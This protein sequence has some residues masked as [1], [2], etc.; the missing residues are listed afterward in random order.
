M[1]CYS[2]AGVSDPEQFVPGSAVSPGEIPAGAVFVLGSFDGVHRGHRALFDAALS[3]ARESDPASPAD[4]A[5]VVVWSLSGLHRAC[6]TTEDEKRVLFRLCGES[7]CV[8]EDFAEIRALPGDTF[9]FDRL[10]AAFRPRAVVCGFNFTFGAGASCTP[11]DLCRFAGEAGIR[12]AVCPPVTGTPVTDGDEPISSTRIRALVTEGRMDEAARL[13]GHPYPVASPVRHGHRIGRTIG[14]PTLN[15]RL[16]EDKIAPP[17]GVYASVSLLARGEER[18]LCPSVSNLGS[19]P[20]VNAD[21]SDVT[22]ETHV[23]GDCGW[24]PAGEYGG[25]LVVWL[26][27]FLRPERKFGSL[28]ELKAAIAADTESALPGQARLMEGY[29]GEDGVLCPPEELL[30]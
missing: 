3:L 13:M 16:P 28:E 19:R 25:P 5:P 14:W 20:T 26:G 27:E 6:L 21:V 4:P 30:L 8:F 2:F 18:I 15:Q 22:L 10:V 7:A 23:S 12:A 17:H 29:P 9:F 11:D 24:E 1:R